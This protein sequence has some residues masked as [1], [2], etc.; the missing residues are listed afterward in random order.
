MAETKKDAL[1]PQTAA[2]LAWLVP[3]LGHFY[4]GR[5]VKGIVFL[6][7]LCGTFFY[8]LY[9][10]GGHVV[11]MKWDDDERHL[12]YFAQI[13]AGALALPGLV[14]WIRAN[15]GAGPLPLLGSFQAPPKKAEL[16]A[17][18][19]KLG[20][21]WEIGTVYTMLAGLLNVLVI[22]DAFAGSALTEDER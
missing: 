7:C 14:Q 18:H 19:K 21:W 4:Q 10:G 12:S 2:L 9:L 6:L 5:T 8:G 1:S 13:G 16:D 11:Y 17:Y 22:Y 20:R 15:R 3:G